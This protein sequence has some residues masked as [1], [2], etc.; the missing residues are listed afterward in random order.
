M[1]VED[2]TRFSDRAGVAEAWERFLAQGEAQGPYSLERPDGSQVEIL[3]AAKA[4]APWPGS[5]ASL[6][7]PVE[8]VAAPGEDDRLDV[9]QALVEAGFVARYAPG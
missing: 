3:Y 9:D 7:V 2:V 1:K 8:E 5:H 6:L 4:N